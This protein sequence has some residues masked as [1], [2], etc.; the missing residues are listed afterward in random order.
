MDSRL[1]IG[2]PHIGGKISHGS[3]VSSYTE[4]E[5]SGNYYRSH[6][7]FH[8]TWYWYDWAYSQWQGFDK[9][10]ASRIK[11]IIDLS[12]CDIIHNMNQDPDIMP[13]DADQQSIPHLTKKGNFVSS[14]I[15]TDWTT[16][17]DLFMVWFL[18]MLNNTIILQQV[19]SSNHIVRI[20]QYY[21]KSLLFYI[22]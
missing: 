8:K 19:M 13:D 4:I 16:P 10:I 15:S 12:Y 7:C 5:K 2:S 22:W 18:I 9:P 1:Y 20:C 6:P 14:R 11:M 3:V 17:I 21:V